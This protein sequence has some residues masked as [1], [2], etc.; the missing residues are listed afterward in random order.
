MAQSVLV[1]ATHPDDECLGCGGTMARHSSKGDS[2][3]VLIVAEGVTARSSFITSAESENEL[4]VL[5]SAA[6]NAANA[7][8][9]QPPEFLSL[10]DNRLDSIAMLDIVKKIEEVVKRTCPDIVYTHHGGDLNIDHRIVHQAVLTACRPLPGSKIRKILAFEILSSTEWATPGADA[11]RP[12]HF[13]DVSAHWKAKLAALRVYESE[14][15]PFPHSRSLE[16]VEALSKFR[17]ASAGMPCAE[18]FMILRSIE[19]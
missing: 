14:M 7:V 15:R 8:G 13:V 4:F 19:Q 1:V 11:F 9:A 2:V 12:N 18:A 10:P 5:R 3:H 6:E 16:A 17:G